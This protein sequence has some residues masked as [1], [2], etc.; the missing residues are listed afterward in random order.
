MIRINIITSLKKIKILCKISNKIQNIDE[1][2]LCMQI[3]YIKMYIPTVLTFTFFYN[4]RL[5]EIILVQIV[6]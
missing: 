4:E 5:H 3:Y 2:E 6:F 1:K